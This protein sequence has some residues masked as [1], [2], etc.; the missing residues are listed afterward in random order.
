MQT[1]AQTISQTVDGA[2][3]VCGKVGE[4]IVGSNE[5]RVST[6]RPTESTNLDA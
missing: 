5:D 3:G 4:R 6:G 2:L 1:N